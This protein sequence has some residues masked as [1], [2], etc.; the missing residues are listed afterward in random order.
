MVPT[1]C[2]KHLN[3]TFVQRNSES[4]MEPS[5]YE[6]NDIRGCFKCAREIKIYHAIRRT[7]PP[8]LGH[9]LFRKE[10]R[11]EVRQLQSAVRTLR[12]TLPVVDN[13]VSPTSSPFRQVLSIRIKIGKKYTSC[14]TNVDLRNGYEEFF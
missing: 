13:S 2:L 1:K 3:E 14:P 6:P 4:G 12:D 8:S 10:W 7:S 9:L 5:F 11:V